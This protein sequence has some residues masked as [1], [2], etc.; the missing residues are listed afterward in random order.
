[1]ARSAG[2]H[3]G[4]AARWRALLAAGGAAAAVIVL[5]VALGRW[6]TP[7]GD[8]PEVV[9]VFPV[10]SNEDVEIVSVDAAGIAAVL[11]GELPFREP[12]V[13]ME[14]GD[15]ALRSVERPRQGTFPEMRLQPDADAAPMILGPVAAGLEPAPAP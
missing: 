7:P 9:E 11:V 10:A 3:R 15:I 5:T 8:A 6:H 1:M 2:P 14:P 4:W 13:L 12:I